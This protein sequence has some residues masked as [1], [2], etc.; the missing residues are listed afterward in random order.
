M[1]TYSRKR[2]SPAALAKRRHRRRDA[3]PEQ[4]RTRGVPAGKVLNCC[5]SRRC[6]A[7][8]PG[9]SSFTVPGSVSSRQSG[10]ATYGR[11]LSASC[12]SGSGLVRSAFTN[13]WPSPPRLT[14][15][16][17]G[18]EQRPQPPGRSVVGPV[19]DDS[20]DTI[21]PYE[22]N[23][24]LQVASLGH[25]AASDDQEAIRQGKGQRAIRDVERRWKVD[26]K[27]A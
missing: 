15:I 6:A 24:S 26:D 12:F 1:A 14:N 8:E 25:S 13:S 4:P 19:E 10:C 21:F 11:T 23:Q 16:G 5:R 27:V 7:A 2:S 17:I 18:L 3:T 22:A 9:M 20:A